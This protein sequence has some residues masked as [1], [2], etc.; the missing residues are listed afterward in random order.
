MGYF[1][2]EYQPEDQRRAAEAL[3]NC[4]ARGNKENP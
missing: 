1:Q 4:I 3:R 2:P